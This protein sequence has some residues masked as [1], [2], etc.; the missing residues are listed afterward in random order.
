[1]YVGYQ[2]KYPWT[3]FNT[4]LIEK[5]TTANSTK[6]KRNKSY[7]IGVTEKLLK[8]NPKNKSRVETRQLIAVTFLCFLTYSL[9]LQL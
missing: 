5:Y 1:M 7:G 8:I 6:Q 3:L 9:S 2:L 4:K